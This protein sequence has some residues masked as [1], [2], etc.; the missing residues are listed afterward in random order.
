MTRVPSTAV[1]L[2][3]LALAL[4]LALPT[5]LPAGRA[6]AQAASAAAE[7]PAAT[8][9]PILFVTQVPNPGD[10][11]TLQAVFGNHRHDVESAPRGGDL[12]IR[13]PDGTLKN[14]TTTA[15][16]GVPSGFQGATSIAV[17]DP[18]VHWDGTRALFSM[19]VGAPRFQ[20]DYQDDWRWQVYEITGLG[21][22]QTPVI[23]R[24]ALQPAEYNNVSPVYGTDDRVIF[25][26]DRPI[27][28]QA[29]LHPQ[30]DEYEEQP[31][32]TG[33]WSLDPQ[34][35][36]LRLLDHAPSGD[37]TPFVDSF[38]RVLFTRWDHLQRDQQADA[39]VLYGD[40]YGTFNWSSEA[41]GSVPT[42]SRAEVFPEP[43]AERTDILRF[44]EV[45]HSFNHFFPWQV[46]EDGSE[47]ETLDHVGRHELHSYFDRA[48][49]DDPNLE[50]FIDDTSGRLNPNPLENLLQVKELPGQPGQ[51]V[52]IDAPEFY[53]HASGQVVTLGGPPP[54]PADQM[55]VA[56]KTHRA[57]ASFNDDGQPAPAGHSGHYR[58][59]LPL[60]DGSFVAAHT[61]ETRADRNEGTRAL[62]QAR[63]HFRLK[64]LVP[65]PDGFLRAGTALTPGIFKTFWSWDPD[66]R[67]D[68]V[69]AEMWELQPV[70]VRARPRPARRVAALQAPEQAIFTQEGI[71]PASF[72]QDLR[73]RGLAAVVSRNVTTRDAADR[74]QPFNLRV[75]NGVQTT[76]ASGRIYDVGLIQFFQ[77]DRLRGLGGTASP[78]P[79]RRVLGQPMH[80]PAAVRPPA[81]AGPLAGSLK[82]G[83]DGSMAALV[84][85]RR[86]L[87]WHLTAPDGTPVVRE[88]YW[89][90]FQPGEVRT[91]A[92][93]HGLNSHDQAGQ[94]VPQNPPEALRALVRYWRDTLAPGLSV[95]ASPA[96]QAEG[97]SG[98]TLRQFT[99][100]LSPA[101]AGPVSVQYATANGTATAGS[102]YGSVSGTLSFAAGQTTRTVEVPVFGD[103]LDEPDESFSLALSAPLG[104]VVR[105]PSAAV[106]TIVDDDAPGLAVGDVVA[107][108]GRGVP[109]AT[110]F[111]VTLAP[112]A[113]GTVTVQYAT[114]DGTATAGSDYAATS[115]TLTFAPGETAKP[116]DVPV[117][118]D[119]LVEAP[120]TFTLDLSAPSGAA[121]AVPQGLAH[122]I[123]APPGGDL[124]GDR[125]T[126]VLWQH[127]VSSRL[128]WWAMNGTVRISGGYTTP[129]SPNGD[130]L[131]RVRGTADFDGDGRLDLLLHRGQTGEVFLWLMNGTT[132][133]SGTLTT[134]PNQDP[135]WRASATADFNSDGHPDVLWRHQA[136]GELRAW[137]MNGA[138]RLADVALAPNSLPDLNWRL[139]GAGDFNGDGKADILWRHALSGRNVAWLMDGTA[140]VSG[141]LLTP[142]TVADTGWQMAGVG[143]FNGDGKPDILWRHEVSSKLVVWLMNGLVRTTGLFTD[144]AA[145]ADPQWQVAG[146][147]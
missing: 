42:S 67:V 143:D 76:G 12:W 88:R 135:A 56:Y 72:Q 78:R 141:A 33:L 80:D 15:G 14:L 109:S 86:A 6:E 23:T 92:S 98:V 147:R 111:T 54:L 102:D 90:T 35:G 16:Y 58:D 126:D 29:H 31:T 65:G 26:S 22:S 48:F 41:P 83:L 94:A 28:G 18:A 64:T 146:P 21:A 136:T 59:P 10:F 113:A 123:D 110:R 82:L 128:V 129:D 70:E 45:G 3:H 107:V 60:S 32:V 37:F 118:A 52:G 130:P 112:A 44:N 7:Q 61:A 81:L 53:T 25:T 66:V 55:L 93:C 51:Y 132:V 2:A 145:L 68:Y 74:Q 140:R 40:T 121:V 34:S 79:G 95:A 11:T 85:A 13:Y 9:W 116:V 119:T 100:T 142:D 96:S 115:G 144:P 125:Q 4:A 114:H 8:P 131:W 137:L 124:T 91:C 49:N 47:L 108:E 106:A 30:L 134:P 103:R 139:A 122:L 36:D 5:S 117:L 43:R 133:A 71:D 138:T 89:L 1:R 73:A 69:N 97:S 127:P 120:E 77:A 19:V 62:P 99:V 17:R 75:P 57:T 20:Y 105:G 104:G 27:D 24:L 50:E 46:N 63:Y 87:S 101:S 38:G 39:D 84:P